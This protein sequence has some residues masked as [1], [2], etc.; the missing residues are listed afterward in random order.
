MS[1]LIGSICVFESV[2]CGFFLQDL[3][4]RCGR[5]G[6]DGLRGFELAEEARQV[7]VPCAGGVV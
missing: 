3:E 7:P 1:Y 6:D 5:M 4:R 2:V